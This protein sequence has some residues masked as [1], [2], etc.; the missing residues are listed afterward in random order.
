M[1]GCTVPARAVS[2]WSRTVATRGLSVFTT[3][4]QYKYIQA[5]NAKG[6]NVLLLDGQLDQHFVGLLSVGLQIGARYVQRNVRRVDHT[7]HESHELR[8]DAFD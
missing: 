8:H 1:S 4:A 7:L 5:A 3:T 6:Y 2:A